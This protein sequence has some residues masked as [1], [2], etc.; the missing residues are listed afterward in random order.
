MPRHD[1]LTLHE[2][3]LLLALKNRKGTTAIESHYNLAMG[4]AILA[5]LLLLGRIQV[6]EEK[7]RRFAIVSSTR[8]TGDKLLDECLGRVAESKKRQQ[9]K[10]WVSRFSNTSK[11]KRRVA[12]QLCRKGVLRES[13]DRVLFL[14]KRTIY[15]ELDPRPE[16]ALVER[17]RRAIFT[18]TSQVEPRTAVLV[19]LAFHSDLLKNAF[20]KKELK[21][22]KKRIESLAGGDV[23]GAATKEAIQAVEAAAA[24]VVVTMATV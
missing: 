23:V 22:R 18:S 13:E 3:I 2:E 21:S 8:S 20:A 10:T 6:Q 17:L 9:M 1:N 5:E 15:P 7:K 4:G 16:R 11:L 14:F 19:A 12:V 24:I